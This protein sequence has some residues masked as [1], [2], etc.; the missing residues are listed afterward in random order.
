MLPNTLYQHGGT[1]NY[2]KLTYA[3]KLTDKEFTLH[4][5]LGYISLNYPLNN[6][7]VLAVA[8]RYTYNGVE[9]Q[10]GEF[11]TDI[12]VDPNNPKVL[13]TKLLKNET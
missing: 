6:D 5:Q 10:V 3:R 11:S 7:E 4:P 1:D 8:Y 9:Y 13:F 12:P 2:S